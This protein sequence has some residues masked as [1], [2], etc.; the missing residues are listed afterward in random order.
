MKASTLQTV[1]VKLGDVVCLG[2]G[3]VYNERREAVK[4]G[5]PECKGIVAGQPAPDAT[6]AVWPNA[7]RWG[8][9]T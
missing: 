5:C 3:C 4:R 6:E 7:H 9:L 1:A 8:G 2:C